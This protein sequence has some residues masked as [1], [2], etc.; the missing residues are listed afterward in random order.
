MVATAD[1]HATPTRDSSEH[2]RRQG[3]PSP[4]GPRTRGAVGPRSGQADVK[5]LR[6][7]PVALLGPAPGSSSCTRRINPRS[8]APRYPPVPPCY[9]YMYMLGLF[10][11]APTPTRATYT[12][13][14]S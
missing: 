10:P 4:S 12:P 3:Q 9:M 8:N 2:Q 6:K 14:R 1:R 7:V 5:M 13:S 11:L